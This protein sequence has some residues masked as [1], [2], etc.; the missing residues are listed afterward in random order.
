MTML[1]A[2]EKVMKLSRIF[3]L[4]SKENAKEVSLI[5]K[6]IRTQIEEIKRTVVVYSPAALQF[7]GP[8]DYNVNTI[9]R[10]VIS[11]I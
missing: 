2:T 3:A 9:Q 1:K 11:S 6:L 5:S 7:I 4:R 8:G 10:G